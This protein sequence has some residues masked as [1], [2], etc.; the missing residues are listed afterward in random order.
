MEKL[1]LFLLSSIFTLLLLPQI[2]CASA[3]I[4]NTASTPTTIS[5]FGSPNTATIG[6]AFHTNS[7]DTLLNDFSMFLVRGDPDF[8]GG[9]NLSLRGYIG[10]WNG[11]NVTSILYS[12][13]NATIPLAGGTLSFAPAL[14][15]GTNSNYIAFL[16]ISELPGQTAIHFNMPGSLGTSDADPYTDGFFYQ[17]NGSV[18][19]TWT[20]IVWQDLGIAADIRLVADLSAPES[21]VPEPTTLALLTFGLAGLGA[22]R[23]RS[24]E[25]TA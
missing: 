22:S 4:D 7:S 5:T 11:T 6:E 10:T 12:S 14:Q 24:G 25:N 3:I 15:L 16:S 19:S 9:T 2:T 17:N 18:P 21:E 23:R 13:S 8:T 1:R 20:G